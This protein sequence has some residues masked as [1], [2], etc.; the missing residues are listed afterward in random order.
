MD[1]GRQNPAC[2]RRAA[3]PRP[4]PWTRV[5]SRDPA[6]PGPRPDHP[7]VMLSLARSH[8]V[9]NTA[10]SPCTS[11]AAAAALL[12]QYRHLADRGRVR[13]PG[14]LLRS[15]RSGGRLYFPRTTH[16]FSADHGAHSRVWPE[17]HPGARRRS[18]KERMAPASCVHLLSIWSAAI[19]TRSRQPGRVGV[20][21]H[22]A[23]EV[24]TSAWSGRGLA[25]PAGTRLA[26]ASRAPG[27]AAGPAAHACVGT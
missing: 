21:I 24:P 16:V 13:S 19:R 14:S 18:S 20:M 17:Q 7:L 26:C 10:P 22:Q 9:K 23:W 27:E 3:R 15:A 4:W 6:G 2:T 8:R 5:P 25:S 12:K 11:A 1:T